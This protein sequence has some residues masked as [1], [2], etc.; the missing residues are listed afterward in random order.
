MRTFVPSE[1]KEN[2]FFLRGQYKMY[3][4]GTKANSK[5]MPTNINKNGAICQSKNFSET[6]DTMR[7]LKTFKIISNEMPIL[8][9][10]LC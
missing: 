7:Q 9:L 5:M 1:R 8:L 2:L 4:P 6:S 10:T 3:T